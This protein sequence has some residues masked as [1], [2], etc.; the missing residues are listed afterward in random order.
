MC[1]AVANAKQPAAYYVTTSVFTKALIWFAQSIDRSLLA[2]C[3]EPALPFPISHKL[4]SFSFSVCLC[5]VSALLMLLLSMLLW[6]VSGA[7]SPRMHFGEAI[8]P[9][10]DTFTI[11][12][13]PSLS[14]RPTQ[15]NDGWFFSFKIDHSKCEFLRHFW[16]CVGNR[17]FANIR[18][19]AYVFALCM[20]SVGFCVHLVIASQMASRFSSKY[21][22]GS[23]LLAHL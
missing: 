16:R 20:V 8:K 4:P 9:T 15:I 21:S 7:A 5:G 2:L 10:A 18:F 11:Y 1:Q 3:G 17:F 6:P 12:Q 13:C 19:Q 23:H 14:Y 22:S